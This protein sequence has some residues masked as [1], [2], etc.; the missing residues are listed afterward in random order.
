M[1]ITTSVSYAGL[2]RMEPYLHLS[3]TALQSM[4]L[5]TNYSLSTENATDFMSRISKF[6]YHRFFILLFLPFVTRSDELG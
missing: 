6:P 5:N 4:A 1:P 2:E 3:P